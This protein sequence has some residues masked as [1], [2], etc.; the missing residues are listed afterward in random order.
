[1]QAEKSWKRRRKEEEKDR[2]R[3]ERGKRKVQNTIGTNRAGVVDSW[4]PFQSLISK[5]P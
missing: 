4:R 1:M 2:R 3:K 5:K